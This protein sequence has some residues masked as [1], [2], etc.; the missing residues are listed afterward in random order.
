MVV[1]E[2]LAAARVARGLTTELDLRSAALMIGGGIDAIVAESLRD[3][4]YD[5][6]AAAELLVGVVERGFLS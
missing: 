1:A 3:P 6:I 4:A 5:A 2:L